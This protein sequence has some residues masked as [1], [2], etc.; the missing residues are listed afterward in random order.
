MTQ[1]PYGG[2]ASQPAVAAQPAGTEHGG[3]ARRR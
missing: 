2:T 3:S 1:S